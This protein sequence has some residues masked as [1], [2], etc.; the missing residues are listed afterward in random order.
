MTSRY[1]QKVRE[2]ARRFLEH[3]EEIQASIVARPRGWTQS[4]A[5]AAG[6][7][8]LAAA[9]GRRKVG[10]NIAAAAEAGFR[11]TS[12][13]ALAVSQRRLLAFKISEP[14]G[15]GIGGAVKE[16]VSAVPVAAVDG[17]TIKRL[18]LGKT[19]TVTVRGVPFAL[20]AGA[21]ADAKGLVAAFERA[22][23]GQAEFQ[24]TAVSYK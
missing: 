19:I 8:A 12:P 11:I 17:I 2:T 6:P 7:A 9:M 13:M 4:V 24:R 23:D 16:L 21:M 22:R 20:E 10:G 14:F 18:L 5:G 1:E 3:G 15:F